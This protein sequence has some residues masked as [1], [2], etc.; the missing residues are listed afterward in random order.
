MIFIFLVHVWNVDVFEPKPLTH[1]Y[2]GTCI[3]LDF[4]TVNQNFRYS[5]FILEAS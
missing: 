1:T 4:K 3:G 5:T 2:I